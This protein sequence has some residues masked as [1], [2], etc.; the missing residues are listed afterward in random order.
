MH[1]IGLRFADY[2]FALTIGVKKCSFE[3]NCILLLTQSQSKLH[4]RIKPAEKFLVSLQG[5]KKELNMK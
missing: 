5:N 4:P 1:L 3:K 2:S